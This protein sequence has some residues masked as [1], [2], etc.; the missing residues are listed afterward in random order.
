MWHNNSKVCQFL[1][2]S[3][4][5]GVSRL[6]WPVHYEAYNM[7]SVSCHNGHNAELTQG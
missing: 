6:I 1:S 3:T 7:N 4:I 2:F 5:L